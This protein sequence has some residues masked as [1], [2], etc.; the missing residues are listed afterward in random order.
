M[1]RQDLALDGDISILIGP[2]GGGKTNLLDAVVVLLRRY[3]FAS[4]WAAHAPT[5]ENPNRHEFRANDALN[6]L[7]LER[8][9]QAPK[10]LEQLVEAGLLVEAPPE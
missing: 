4:M 1:E 6:Q 5:A 8:H 9:T 2:N 10:N 7:T 3:L